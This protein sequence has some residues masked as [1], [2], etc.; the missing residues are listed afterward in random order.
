MARIAI[1]G[2]TNTFAPVEADLAQCQHSD[3]RQ[4]LTRA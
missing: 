2:F 4:S 3:A 1:G